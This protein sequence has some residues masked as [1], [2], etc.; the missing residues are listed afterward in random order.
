MCFDDFEIIHSYSR[1][2][3]IQDGVLVDVSVHARET[4]ILPPTA[5]TGHLHN[6]L[7]EIPSESVGQDYRGR[8]HDVLWMAY[9]RLKQL[10]A[11]PTP[12]DEFPAEFEVLI[13]GSIH[14]LW[15]D[16]DGDGVTIL[17][18]EDH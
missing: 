13:D 9:L 15:V 17:Y 4:G 5:I 3:A 6:V 11:G 18:P 10:A 2:E 8:L 1:A 16:L 7:E 14:K 12:M